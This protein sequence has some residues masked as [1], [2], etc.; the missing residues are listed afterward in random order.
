MKSKKNPKT[1]MLFLFILFFLCLTNFIYAEEALFSVT[2]AGG[3]TIFAVYPSG[4]IIKKEITVIDSSGNNQIM[5]ANSDSIR[6]YVNEAATETSRG[7]FAIGGVASRTSDEYFMVT[8]DSVRIYIK[9]I[10]STRASRGGFAVGGVASRSFADFLYVAPDS[11]RI[12]VADSTAGFSIANIET[13]EAENFLNL[14]KNNYLIGHE[15][16]INISSGVY[17]SFLGYQTGHSTTTG[18]ENVFIGYQC[19]KYGGSGSRNVFLGTKAGYSNGSGSDNVF[20]GFHTGYNNISGYNT[21]IGTSAGES[22]TYGAWNTFLGY[23]SGVTNSTGDANSFFGWGA[24]Y[25]TNGGYNTCIGMYSGGENDSGNSNAYFGAHCAA[26][27]TTGSNN[28]CIGTFS[29]GAA[30]TTS[31]SNNVFL[32]YKAGY[33][34]T[35]SDKLYIENS[36]SS[37]PLIWGDFEND[38]LTFNADVGIGISPSRALSFAG[39]GNS[40]GIALGE[41]QTTPVLLYHSSSALKM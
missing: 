28:T 9:D 11:T 26:Y 21:F 39:T 5:I 6:M 33:D 15:S 10:P 38:L 37:S 41:D 31:G 40:N 29:G 13:G 27:N 8:P 32:G 22:N 18:N 25:L 35:S 12:F 14:N 36:D 30:T 16:V 34:E 3:D 4:I 20:I 19:G 17:N 23:Q 7:G 2:T 1:F 24:G